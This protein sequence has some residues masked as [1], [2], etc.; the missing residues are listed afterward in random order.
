MAKAKKAKRGRPSKGG[1]VVVGVRL[2]K[3]DYNWLNKH[4]GK[5]ELLCKNY[6]ETLLTDK[7]KEK[8]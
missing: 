8:K 3:P 7:P 1:T 5:P 2:T 4:K 6:L